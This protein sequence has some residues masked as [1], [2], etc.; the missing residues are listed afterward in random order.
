MIS[1]EVDPGLTFPGGL[2][3]QAARATLDPTGALDADLSVVLTGDSRI[4]VLN[5]DFLKTD[6]PT[7]VLSF[8]A[9]ESDPETG[10]HYLGDVIVSLPRAID[11]A[12]ERGHTVEAE[13]QLLV[14]HGVLHLLGYDHN[15]AEEKTRMWAAQSEVL[16]RLGISP[17]IVHE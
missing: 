9:K 5:R 17:A 2:L 1:I 10:R 15:K 11:Q 12:T 14:V 8:P 4:Q 13:V 16:E 3:E 6:S 7:D